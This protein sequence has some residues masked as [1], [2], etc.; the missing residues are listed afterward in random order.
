MTVKLETHITMICEGPSCER[1]EKMLADVDDSVSDAAW[2]Y[3]IIELMDNKKRTF[4]S[5]FCVLNWFKD[6]QPMES[7]RQQKLRQSQ[8]LPLIPAD[9]ETKVVEKE[10]NG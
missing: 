3:I 2:R 10:P 4:C 6:Y 5:K 7:P 8:Q 9:G 1:V